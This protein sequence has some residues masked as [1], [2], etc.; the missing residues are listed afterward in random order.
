MSGYQSANVYNRSGSHKHDPGFPGGHCKFQLSRL[1]W[2]NP[3]IVCS[4]LL[5]FCLPAFAD[6][7]NYMR[8]SNRDQL[9]R[10]SCSAIAQHP[11]QPVSSIAG[12]KGSRLDHWNHIASAFDVTNC[13]QA[14]DGGIGRV[15]VAVAFHRRDMVGTSSG[16]RRDTIGI[17]SFL[18]TSHNRTH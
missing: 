18:S 1:S 9:F 6:K 7:T 10:L 16:H 15:V 12:S 4:N 17:F 2:N 14:S 13:E 5:A 11:V 3:T 8:N